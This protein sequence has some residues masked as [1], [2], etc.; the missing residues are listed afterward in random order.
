MVGFV[1]LV[2]WPLVTLILFRSFSLKMALVWSVV[3][4]YLL[5]PSELEIFFN[6][7][8]FP[9]LDKRIIPIV[10]AAVFATVTVKQLAQQSRSRSQADLLKLTGPVMPGWIPKARFAQLSMAMMVVGSVGTAMTNRDMLFYGEVVV[11]ALS[12]YDGLAMIAEVS[13][14]LMPLIVGRKFLAD[15]ESHK[16]L[17]FVLCIAALIYSLPALFEVRMSPQM[18]RMVYDFFPHSWLQHIR[19]GG[20]RPLVFLNHGLLLGIFTCCAILA[21]VILYRIDEKRRVLYLFA[22]PWLIISLFLYKTAGAFIFAL[23]FLPLAMFMPVRLQLMA[24]AIVAGTTLTYPM[25]RGSGIIP[26]EQILE[27]ASNRLDPLRAGS[28]EFRFNNEDALL[29]L[30]NERPVFGWGGWGRGRQYDEQGRDQSTTDGAWI[31]V[32]GQDGW[33]GYISQFGLMTIPMLLLFFR[34]KRYKVSLVTSGLCLVLAANTLDLLPNAS[35]TPILWLMAGALLGRLEPEAQPDQESQPSQDAPALVEMRVRGGVGHRRPRR[36]PQPQDAQP[37]LNQ[38]E[39][40]PDETGR[41]TR[42]ATTKHRVG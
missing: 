18:N 33:I 30:A 13:F 9:S 7:P 38:S 37:V 6:I 1:A 24:A 17:L 21:T 15:E 16:T 34:R 5:L 31:I 20:W 28:L 2:I 4:G 25:L 12:Y 39:D 23:L 26:T 40:L 32:I 3:A 27:V 42:F 41:Y 35:V 22:L 8:L 36:D 10:S 11:P 29:Q 14:F 19:N